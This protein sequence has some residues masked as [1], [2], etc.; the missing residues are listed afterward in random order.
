M[1]SNLQAILILFLIYGVVG[2]MFLYWASIVNS[3][4]E[5][6]FSGLMLIYYAAFLLAGLTGIAETL[7]STEE[8]LKEQLEGFMQYIYLAVGIFTF[9]FGGVGTNIVAS[10]ITSSDNTKVEREENDIKR[11]NINITITKKFRYLLASFLFIVSLFILFDFYSLIKI[12]SGVSMIENVLLI[13][14]TIATAF[15]AFAA[16]FSYSVSRNTLKFQKNYAKNQNLLNELNSTL[17][18]ARALKLIMSSE[19]NESNGEI[20]SLI[21]KLK[22]MLQ[23]LNE[24]GIIDYQALKLSSVEDVY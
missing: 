18:E 10:A 2:C 19:P 23:K 7:N 20:T 9:L 24:A 11:Q 21:I 1:D 8:S 15:A 3:R 14:T 6:F 16:W 13:F 17:K 22:S 4:I 12:L 5:K